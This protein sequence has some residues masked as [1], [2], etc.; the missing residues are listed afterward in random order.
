RRTGRREAV[1]EG[2]ADQIA[3]VVRGFSV[4]TIY[5]ILFTIFFV[6]ASPY[7]F[8]R[9]RRRGNWVDGFF[10]RFGVFDTKI[11]QS[12]TNR[13]IIWLHAVSVSEVNLCTQLIRS[14]EPR[15]PNVKIIVSTTTTTGMGL[16]KKQLPSHISR[17]YF[18]I[19]RRPYVSRAIATLRP[20]AIVLI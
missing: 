20:E 5:N 1:C 2:G 3:S 14:L 13:H 12:V 7:Y 8:W 16:L 17:I 4:R 19:D 6:L 10:Q 15:L 9:M 18:P 11:K